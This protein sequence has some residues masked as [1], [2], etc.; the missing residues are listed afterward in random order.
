VV[1]FSTAPAQARVPLRWPDLPG[2][3]WRLTDL[4][5]GEEFERDGAELAGPGL[6]VAMRPGQSYVFSVRPLSPLT[7][8]PACA[9]TSA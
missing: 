5:D 1:N 8:S 6:F 7:G 3:T 4:I 2:R 9:S